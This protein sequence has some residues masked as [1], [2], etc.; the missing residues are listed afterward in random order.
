MTKNAPTVVTQKKKHRSQLTI[1]D[2]RRIKASQAAFIEKMQTAQANEHQQA[3]FEAARSNAGQYVILAGPGSG[4]TFTAIKAST[5]FAGNAMYC[6]YNRK[7]R[8]DTELKLVAID[9]RMGATTAHSFGLSCLKAFTRGK[10][11]LDDDDEKYHNIVVE[12]LNEYWAT[13][14]A[15]IDRQLEE[16]EEGVD[17]RVMRLDALAWSKLLI[18]FAQVSLTEPTPDGLLRL[19]EDFDL[20]DIGISS[21]VW[22]FVVEAVPHALGRGIM[23]FKKEYLVSFD[24]MVWLPN[25]LDDIPI[26]QYDHIVVDE[27]QDISRAALE[28]LLKACHGNTQ[29]FFIGDPRQS[30]YVFAGA[31]FDSIV[32]I[33]AR[34]NANI[35]PLRV[36]YRCGSNI[37]DVVNQLC[38]DD[39][40]LISAKL[41]DGHVEVLPID[42]YLDRLEPGDAVLARMTVHL[43]QACLMCLQKGKRA[44]VLG[45]DL[46]MN[47]A[48]VVTRL[49]EMRVRRGVP[50]LRP[51]LSNLLEVLDEHWKRET[52]TLRESRKNPDLA[53]AELEDKVE[54][55]RA[56]FIAYIAKCNDDGLRVTDD[57][58]CAWS[59]S[60]ADFKVYIN[61]LFVDGGE[62]NLILF[63]TAHRS[64]GSEWETVYIIHPE[65]FPHPKAKSDRQLQQESNLMY[66]AASRAIHNLYFVGAPFESVSVPGYEL[67]APVTI[68]SYPATDPV[69]IHSPEFDDFEQ[70]A[71]TAMI[72]APETV[73]EKSVVPAVVDEPLTEG[74]V[75]RIAAVEVLCPACGGPCA[76]TGTGSL[77]ITHELRGHTVVCSLCKKACVVPLNA[78]SISGDIVAREKPTQLVPNAKVEKQGRRKKERKSNAGAKPQGKEPKQPL[79]LSLDTRIIRV[80]KQWGVNASA[81]FVELLQQYQPFLEMCQQVIEGEE[82]E[83]DVTE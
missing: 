60:A 35:L 10:A 19:V 54:T 48:A 53:L 65:Q 71:E 59:R 80:I 82:E 51:D 39:E 31:D 25:V 4:K 27:A 38:E 12:Y 67:P 13:Y 7:V 41:H 49:E 40:K 30:I 24:D 16:I 73:E 74:K 47:I 50:M 42:G 14:L 8:E 3:I 29:I 28:L 55:V 22:P 44:K 78:F 75:S 34:L 81:L 2:K 83:D 32:R 62:G 64:K 21:F 33:I 68:I 6:S 63:L 37:V 58:K 46:G 61:G 66:V 52:K 36:C 1:A 72:A 56:M 11:K 17:V 9:S 15:S 23:L 5:F 57:P 45:R 26:R 20:S 79:Q 43:V 70:F 18:H 69:E 76:A 77:F